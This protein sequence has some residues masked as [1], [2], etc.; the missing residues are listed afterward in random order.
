VAVYLLLIFLLS[1]RSDLPVGTGGWDKA[2][3][4]LAYGVLGV[5][6]VRAFHGGLGRLRWIPT[7][8]ALALTVGYGAFDEFHQSFVAGREA[9]L[10]DLA[11]DAL[12]A[13][14]ATGLLVAVF[15]TGKRPDLDPEVLEVTLV[16]CPGCPDC[17]KS[18]ACLEEA[19]ESVPFRILRRR[20][21]PSDHAA[22]LRPSDAPLIFLG[23]R[24]LGRG[25]IEASEL[26]RLL[27]RA[28]ERKGYNPPSASQSHRSG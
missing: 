18:L 12:G 23:G 27:K 3:H 28:A 1:A 16:E 9:D 4:A 8:S 14:L 6:S 24:L 15:G 22:G 17:R 26:I 19:V 13:G 7:L 11:A 10:W 21:S 5:L 20:V 25:P 2:L